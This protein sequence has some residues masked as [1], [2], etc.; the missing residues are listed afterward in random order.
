MLQAQRSWWVSDSPTKLENSFRRQD[1]VLW[2]SR[3]EWALNWDFPPVATK[4]CESRCQVTYTISCGILIAWGNLIV[5]LLVSTINLDHISSRGHTCVTQC[6]AHPG[7]ARKLHLEDGV[8]VIIWVKSDV[9][10]VVTVDICALNNRRD[11]EGHCGGYSTRQNV[12]F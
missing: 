2:V 8:C 3:V 9:Y 10:T 12:F 7:V 5:Y 1:I 11:Y 6:K 4:V